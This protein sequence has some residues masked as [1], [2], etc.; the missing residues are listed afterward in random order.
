M[1]HDESMGACRRPIGGEPCPT[2]MRYITDLER[3]RHD[4]LTAAETVL[5]LERPEDAFADD[6]DALRAVVER[7][8]A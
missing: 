2:W 1:T 4:L 7:V 6:V 5:D 8:R 3:D